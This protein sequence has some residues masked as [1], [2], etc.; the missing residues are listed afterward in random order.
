MIGDAERATLVRLADILIPRAEG[1]PCASEAGIAD[2]LLDRLLEARPD[3]ATPLAE[4]LDDAATAD[5]P[6]AFLT[7]L[8]RERPSSFDALTMVVGGGYYMS[9]EIWKLLG[10]TGQQAKTIDIF[11]LPPY[12]EEG[13]L[14]AVIERGDLYRPTPNEE[15]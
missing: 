9:P 1:M 13:L 2:E 10:Y 14:D 3:L 15:E 4:V 6:E 7:T 11:E 8:E 5:D 12:I